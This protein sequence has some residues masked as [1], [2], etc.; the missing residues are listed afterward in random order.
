MIKITKKEMCCGCSACA[1][2][3][4]KSCIEMKKDSE[5][6]LYPEVDVS[7]CIDCGLC[8]KTCRVLHPVAEETLEQKAFLVQHGDVRV[9]KESTSGGAFTAISEYVIDR[10]GIVF[11]A[12]FDENFVVKHT[13]AET[14][15]ELKKF[16]NSKYVQSEIAG[17]YEKAKGYL[18]N[19]RFVCFSG[20]PCQIEGLLAYLR[21]PYENLLTVDVV[22]RAVP[23]PLVW[24]KYR[25][26]KAQ[27]REIIDA[28]FR[29]KEPY[30]YEY[31]QI[32]MTFPEKKIKG[33]VE[34]DFY[35][36]A[37]FS[38]LSDRPSCYECK[39][40]KRCRPSDITIWDCFDVYKFDKSMDD[41]TGVTRALVHSAKG[42][43]V[44]SEIGKTNLIKEI[45]CEDAVRGVKEMV[46][47]TKRGEKREAFFADLNA[48]DADACFK[49][50]FPMTPRVRVEKFVR[51]TSERL[52]IYKHVKRLAM[53]VI[54]KK[55]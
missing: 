42:R 55:N 36:R 12:A 43:A 40:K 41:N 39:F 35:L 4:P 26:L 29:D 16:R 9:R 52:G 44:M 19:G 5:G 30:G 50:Y 2:V 20:T 51:N 32:T 47:P 28:K 46:R 23:S 1:A 11:G 7:Q 3:C 31:S 17:C 18:D 6:F 49:K 53:K 13:C 45:S 25:K 33:G 15:E 14:A 21:K 54:K 34:S 10:G 48:M 38:N 22:C 37:F 8:D 27:N 24:E